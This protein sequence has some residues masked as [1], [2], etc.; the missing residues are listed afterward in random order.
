MTEQ[1]HT[2]RGKRPPDAAAPELLTLAQEVA[3]QF[4]HTDAPLGIKARELIA[5]ATGGV[6][7]Q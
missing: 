5:K 3:A 6:D 7:P 4:E 1:K 2:A